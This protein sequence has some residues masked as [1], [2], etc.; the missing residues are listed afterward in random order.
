VVQRKID[1]L[2]AGDFRQVDKPKSPRIDLLINGWVEHRARQL[3]RMRG[4]DPV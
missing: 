4:G 2:S 3:R 1:S